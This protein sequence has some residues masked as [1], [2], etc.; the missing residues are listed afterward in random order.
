MNVIILYVLLIICVIDPSII[1]IDDDWLWM[2]EGNYA[3]VGRIGTVCT[4]IDW[5]V[6][7]TFS[8]QVCLSFQLVLDKE[9]DKYYKK[10]IRKILCY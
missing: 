10:K 4:V 5:F 2:E 1:I 6:S 8:S 3:S 7:Y 9:E